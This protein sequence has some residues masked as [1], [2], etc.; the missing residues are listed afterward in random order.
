[1]K[2]NWLK[3]LIGE[4]YTEQIDQE[5]TKHLE[6]SF[7]SRKDFDTVTQEKQQLYQKLKDFDKASVEVERLLEENKEFQNQIALLQS[8]NQSIQKNAAIDLALTQAKGRN[9]RA[10]KAL[11]DMDKVTL[12]EDGV[13]KGLDLEAIHQSAPY[14]FDTVEKTTR[15]TGFQSGS[16]GSK[17]DIN[18]M[19]YSELTAYLAANPNTTV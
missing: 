10:I 17:V 2:Q 11:I 8:E 5:V 16:K 9:L 18:K 1:M 19:N 7:V 4:A 15:G 3:E 12:N 14:L 13:L 6:H